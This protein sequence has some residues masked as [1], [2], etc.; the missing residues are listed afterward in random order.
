MKSNKN[1]RIA[2]VASSYRPEVTDSLLNHCL[3]TLTKKGL[4]KKQ[5]DVV[6]VPGSLEIPLASKQLAKKKMYDA[7]IVFGTVYKGKTYHFEQ[8]ANE[9][10]RG[11]MNVS[12]EFD[13]PVIFEVLSVYDPQDALDRATGIQDNRGVEGALT[14]LKMIEVMNNI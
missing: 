2:I 5:I 3:E 8:V 14:A 10:V 4:T 1:A 12:Y 13:I 6:R 9:C 11:C 7:I